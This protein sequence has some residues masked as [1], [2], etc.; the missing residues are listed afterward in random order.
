VW[1]I[2]CAASIALFELGE[3]LTSAT[4]EHRHIWANACWMA[5][6]VFAT[7]HCFSTAR[8]ARPAVKRS[9]WCFTIALACWTSAMFVWAYYELVLGQLT[10]FPSLVDVLSWLGAPFM[11]AGIFHYKTRDR[12]RVLGLKQ[13][14]DL[15]LTVAAIVA[16]AVKVLYVPAIDANHPTAFVAAA[17]STTVIAVTGVTF[18]LLTLWQHVDGPRRS[19]LATILV[20][21]TLLCTVQVLYAEALLAGRY[22]AGTWIDVL[23]LIAF[24]AFA[25]AA[26]EERRLA[27]DIK[28][29]QV[30]TARLDP[31]VPTTALVVWMLAWLGSSEHEALLAIN[32]ITGTVLALALF[33]RIW[34]TQRHERSLA[35]RVAREEARAWQLE[36]RLAHVHKLE[37]IGTLAG[38]VAH[39]F[40][41]VLAAATGGLKLA[42][43]KQQRGE[44]VARDLAEVEAVLWRAADLTSQLLDLARKREPNPIAIDP[45]DALERVR[46]LLEKVVP[47]GVRLAIER[48]D[49]VP[50]ILVDPS[51]LEHALLNLGLNARDAVRER[52]GTITMSARSARDPGIAGSAVVIEVR[53]DGVGISA[54]QLP[55]VFEPF[56]TT[57]SEQ[58]TGLGLAMVEAFVGANGGVVSVTSEPGRTTFR[59]AFPAV[60]TSAATV[61]MPAPTATVLVVS[62]EDAA[63]LATAGALERGGIAAVVA[64]DATMAVAECARLPRVDAVI[65]D[66]ATGLAGRD[67]IRALRDAGVRASSVLLVAPGGDDDGD[68]T[69]IVSKP[70][71]PRAL[72]EEVQR[73]IATRVAVAEPP[74]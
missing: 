70:Y 48:A 52:G 31:I 62:R 67:A 55:H 51:G 24:L 65:V 18:G 20:G 49:E 22:R 23:W 33:V 32:A 15:A 60:T 3:W 34:A 40:N 10:P 11:V 2:G 68:W 71:D 57:K 1:F 56:F 58:G 5:V 41:N 54:Q 42:R 61:T 8:R 25:T 19:V 14:A 39:D 9:W 44:S 69:A 26:R 38:G 28:P 7:A 35:A 16:V 50:A 46:I 17:L 53:D 45:R 36:A 6:D 37:A 21:A 59:L 73:A 13:G 66:G 12:S 43:R 74:G 72:V 4:P 64:R 27:D 30:P 29:V 47:S 63:G